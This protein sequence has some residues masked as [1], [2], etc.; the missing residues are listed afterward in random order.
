MAPL[1]VNEPMRTAYLIAN[2]LKQYFIKSKAIF[3]IF[4]IGGVLS[5]SVFAYMYGNLKPKIVVK[6]LTSVEYR[7][8]NVYFNVS[9]DNK[10]NTKIIEPQKSY[11]SAK[12]IEKIVNTGLFESVMEAYEP[13][14][15]LEYEGE[16]SYSIGVV[17][18]GSFG[19]KVRGVA[20]LTETDQVL[21]ESHG[22]DAD[23]GDKIDLYGLPFE[24]KGIC[25]GLSVDCVVMY[26]T[27]DMLG[28]PV[29]F[30]RCVSKENWN[31]GREEGDVPYKTLQ[32]IFP[33]A[34]IQR[35]G[36]FAAAQDNRL[37]QRGV[38]T[39]VVTY[40][41]SAI[42]YVFLM[43]YMTGSLSDENASSIIIGAR[44]ARIG[45]QVFLEGW[46]LSAV[47]VFL[48]LAAHVLLYRPLFSSI[49][50]SEGV[51]YL[52][53]DYVVMACIMFFINAVVMAV[54][55]ARYMMR[56]PVELRRSTI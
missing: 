36:E 19:I 8:Y 26:D 12:N 6:S 18:T 17:N 16:T 27:F 23:V 56:S 40:A 50:I 20:E 46:A 24:V 29:N 4:I 15:S 39:T 53:G 43:I 54:V 33:D 41:V 22:I 2:R 55:S 47:T 11:V 3:I 31:L 28:L 34:Y 7:I 51:Y 9:V 42:A 10:G 5:A 37:A 14:T 49:N 52:F 45:M 13:A 21:L 25:S 1:S 35:T 30:V 38:E 32:E 48:G 44:P